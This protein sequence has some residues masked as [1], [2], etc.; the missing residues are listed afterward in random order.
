MLSLIKYLHNR[1]PILLLEAP[2]PFSKRG[3]SCGASAARNLQGWRQDYQ[4]RREDF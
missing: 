2:F 4:A 1:G 3:W